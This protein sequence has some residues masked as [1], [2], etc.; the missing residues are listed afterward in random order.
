MISVS[1]I[2]SFDR[3][4]DLFA[5]RE[6]SIPFSARPWLEA[7]LRETLTVD[8]TARPLLLG[9]F[10]GATA[11]GLA[12]FVI[13]RQRL[14]GLLPVRTIRFFHSTQSDYCEIIARRGMRE[15]VL[16]A[17]M[18]HLRRERAS[19]DLLM[20]RE[21]PDRQGV[22]EAYE[23]AFAAA[24]MGWFRNVASICYPI[25]LPD[26]WDNYYAALGKKH[27]KGY[28]YYTN[29]L[30]ERGGFEFGVAGPQE[31]GPLLDRFFEL[32]QKRWNVVSLPGSFGDPAHRQTME[33]VLRN[34]FDEGL[35]RLLFLRFDG[36]VIAAAVRFSDG[37]TLYGWLEG[38][39]PDFGMF[40][41]GNTFNYLT[42][43]Y[44][45]ENRYKVYD[46]MRGAHS[47]KT[48][49]GARE[50]SNWVY[51]ASCSK[52]RLSLCS[53]AEKFSSWRQ[54]G[55]NKGGHTARTEDD[56]AT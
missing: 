20:L 37:N 54:T 53:L 2:P 48:G 9:V 23:S 36:K 40:R 6:G 44:A 22:A 31:F 10:D 49:F 28:R 33:A 19:W 5:D 29:K 13:S 47:Y 11:I 15:A 21:I 25:D 51:F 45:I 27:Q 24:G 52:L 17:V 43:Q 1:P 14:N 41:I 42:V 8:A 46:L 55:R 12:P 39:D 32:H 30:R 7:M 26:T 16:H 35:L 50:V 56:H 18:D 38:F 3:V 4:A 34:M